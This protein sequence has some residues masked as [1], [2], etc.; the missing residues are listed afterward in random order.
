MRFM[1]EQ[2]LQNCEH[3][4]RPRIGDGLGTPPLCLCQD[5]V[6]AF[7]ADASAHSGDWIDK[8]AYAGHRA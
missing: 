3:L 2:A 6:S 8:E 5:T 4:Q 1:I 7:E